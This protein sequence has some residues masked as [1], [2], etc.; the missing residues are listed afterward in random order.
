MAG[1]AGGP[2]NHDRS[3][4]LDAILGPGASQ[5]HVAGRVNVA[6]DLVETPDVAMSG[7]Y[8]E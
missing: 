7:T 8:G 1:N 6:G 2:V 4:L 5:H 3:D